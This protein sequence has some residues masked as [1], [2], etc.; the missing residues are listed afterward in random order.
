MTDKSL[1]DANVFVAVA[2]LEAPIGQS[3]GM[4]RLRLLDSSSAPL[5]TLPYFEHGDPGPI[6]A[7]LAHV[8]ELLPPTASFIGAALGPGA[9]STRHK[10]MAILR[11]SAIQGCQYCT[12]AHTVASLASGL[13]DEEVHAL[14][15]EQPWT[16][17]FPSEDEQAL[18]A[19]IDAMASTGPVDELT[20]ATARTRWPDHLLI[21]LAVTI[22]ATILLNRFATGFELPTSVDVAE[23][24]A[25]G[26][27]A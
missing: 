14:R 22:G 11:T 25:A 8:P 12:R 2:Q 1:R 5:S 10:E 24:L 6:V 19:W 4:T 3:H 21:E 7:A 23:R 9:A 27:W 17:S 16:E 15:N 18:L 26:G 20:W 13:T